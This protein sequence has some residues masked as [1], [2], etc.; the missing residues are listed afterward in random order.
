[1]THII[2]CSPAVASVTDYA[3]PLGV[4]F[5]LSMPR[6]PKVATCDFANTAPVLYSI[7]AGVDEPTWRRSLFERFDAVKR[8]YQGW[9]GE[10]MSIMQP[11]LEERGHG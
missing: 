3:R 4:R 7:A 11:R 6:S 1:M 5:C 8:H 2:A 10:A 9:I